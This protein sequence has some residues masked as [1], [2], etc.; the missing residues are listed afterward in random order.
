VQFA[1]L[2]GLLL[3]TLVIHRQTD[4]ALN[5]RLRVPADELVMIRTGCSDTFRHEVLHTP[6]IEAAACSA[7]SLQHFSISSAAFRKPDGTPMTSRLTAVDEGLFELFGLTPLAGR[8]LT[9]G[10]AA[11]RLPAGYGVNGNGFAFDGP[12]P[13]VAAAVIN[14]AAARQL[15]GSTQSALGKLLHMEGEGSFVVF[16]VVGVVADL[17]VDSIREA[18]QPTIYYFAPTHFGL[19]TARVSGGQLP[20]T[21]AAIGRLWKQHGEPRPLDLI[22][23]DRYV[24]QL[25]RDIVRQARAGTVFSLLALTIA[26]LGLFG[27]SASIADRRTR[28][29]GVRKAMG[30]GTGDVLRLLLWQFSQPVLWANLIAWPVAGF[31]MHRWLQGF[32]YRIALSPWLFLAAAAATL[33]IALLTV[34]AH[35]SGVAR[36]RPVVALRHE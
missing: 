33:A 6:G 26:C 35:L 12:K 4:F 18:V 30:A 7:L 34:A 20:A 29:I 17:P 10:R 21:L 5:Q 19:L 9:R 16:E 14:E 25:H 13:P 15:G 31:V 23:F 8:F 3:V 1:I 11:D 24:A 36:S 27:L 28:E 32:P 2:A 22:F